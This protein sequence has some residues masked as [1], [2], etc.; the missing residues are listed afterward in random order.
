[1]HTVAAAVI[2]NTVSSNVYNLYSVLLG[3][4]ESCASEDHELRTLQ[5]KCLEYIAQHVFVKCS[6]L[7]QS[8]HGIC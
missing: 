2:A 7:T 5:A 3:R 6:A 1:M 4:L 8:L